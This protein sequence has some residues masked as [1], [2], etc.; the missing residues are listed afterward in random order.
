MTDSIHNY[1]DIK[2]L[3]SG[4]FSDVYRAQRKSSSSTEVA[5]KVSNPATQ[6]APHS[7][8]RERAVLGVLGGQKHIVPLLSSFYDETDLVLVLPYFPVQLSDISI[9]A[10]DD[11]VKSLIMHEI[12]SAI[13]FLH[14]NE[15]I[16][17]DIKPQNILL[18]SSSGPAY[19]TD[20]GT[21]WIAPSS[22]VSQVDAEQRPGPGIAK[23]QDTLEPDNG[24][25]TDVGT[26]LYRAPELL[27]G[28]SGYGKGVD[29]WSWGCVIAEMY[30]GP[31]RRA[32][33]DVSKEVSELALV[34]AIFQ[35]LGTPDLEEWPVC[36]HLL[37]RC[38]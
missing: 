12:T 5:L 11:K 6:R 27:F 1:A 38:S 19:L 17:R 20:F 13:A 30:R 22:R 33:F 16:H 4:A 31:E 29:L 2:F 9:H 15:V 7:P 26:G 35:T 23:Y 24:K 8:L 21:A 3:A 28:Y 18:A 10:A 32:I 36:S 37:E 34:R 14:E 25:L